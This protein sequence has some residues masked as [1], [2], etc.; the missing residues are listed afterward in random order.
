LHVACFTALDI[1]P[2]DT[3]ALYR[4]CQAHEHLGK[5]DEA[6]K[7]ARKLIQLEPGNKAIQ[8]ILRQLHCIMQ[9][10]V[11]T[12]CNYVNIYMKS[13]VSGILAVLT[14]LL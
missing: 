9:D 2:G 14:I 5:Y 12:L 6:Y 3:K 7:D 13:K 11:S 1:C 8:P 10:K 4:R